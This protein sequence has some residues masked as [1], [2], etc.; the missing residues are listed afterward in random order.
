MIKNKYESFVE[1]IFYLSE[2]GVNIDHKVL[3]ELAHTH[4]ILRVFNFGLRDKK[5]QVLDHWVDA[6]LSPMSH[7]KRGDTV[8]AFACFYAEA[9]GKY[10]LVD[11]PDWS[12]YVVKQEAK[13][14]WISPDIKRIP[15]TICDMDS[16][17]FLFEKIPDVVNPF[18]IN[19]S[20]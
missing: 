6:N 15:H 16:H 3:M 10:V 5:T 20:K 17:F 13:S 14:I 8:K 7:I 1:G 9:I 19:D 2:L 12:G 18:T 4:D 11:K